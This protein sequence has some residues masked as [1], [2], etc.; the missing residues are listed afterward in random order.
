[1]ELWSWWRWS[2]DAVTCVKEERAGVA[3]VKQR[4]G[5]GKG[6]DEETMDAVFNSKPVSAAGHKTADRPGGYINFDITSSKRASSRNLDVNGGAKFRTGAETGFRICAE[7]VSAPVRKVAG[8][9]SA[10]VRKLPVPV[11]TAGS[12]SN[13]P[14]YFRLWV[15]VPTAG[16]YTSRST[17]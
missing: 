13:F 4:A 17:I 9:L 5:V 7:I 11:R 1:M 12:S 2:F 14:K 15:L 10:P 3:G 16:K 6:N 8:I